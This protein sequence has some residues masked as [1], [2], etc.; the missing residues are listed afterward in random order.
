M[1]YTSLVYVYEKYITQSIQYIHRFNYYLVINKFISYT[2]IFRIINKLII[3]SQ[4]SMNKT[5]KRW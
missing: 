1:K 3:L 5:M 2:Y 4:R